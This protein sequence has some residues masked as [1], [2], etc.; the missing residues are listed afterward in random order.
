MFQANLYFR[1]ED[2]SRFLGGYTRSFGHPIYFEG[3][4][5][6]LTKT[7]STTKQSFPVSKKINQES[8]QHVILSH[9]LYFRMTV[10]TLVRA[11][12]SNINKRRSVKRNVDLKCISDDK[13]V[14][15]C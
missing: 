4:L 2:S 5:I 14:Q 12:C 6:L 1:Y 7:K 8:F 3:D 15:N 9:M 13:I 11:I 10:S